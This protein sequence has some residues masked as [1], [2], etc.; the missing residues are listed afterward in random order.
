MGTLASWALL[1]REEIR[2]WL[3]YLEHRGPQDSRSVTFKSVYH[4]PLPSLIGT[5]DKAIG[6]IDKEM[7]ILWVF[8]CVHT[9][10]NMEPAFMIFGGSLTHV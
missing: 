2:V 5:N 7:K 8:T 9:R 6:T 3:A 4:S 10:V 1:E